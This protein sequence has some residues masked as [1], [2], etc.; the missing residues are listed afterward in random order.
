MVSNLDLAIVEDVTYSDLPAQVPA[1][2]IRHALATRKSRH[3]QHVMAIANKLAYFNK[4]TEW[5][6]ECERRL[7]VDPGAVT[8]TND[9]MTMAFP[10]SCVSHAIVGPN[11]TE[12]T[13]LRLETWAQESG[14]EVLDMRYSRRQHQP[15]F[16]ASSTTLTWD[17]DDFSES[18]YQCSTCE[19]PLD[20]KMNVCDWCDISEADIASA[21]DNQFMACLNHGII[22]SVPLCFAGVTIRGRK[23]GDAKA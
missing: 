19:E 4:R 7:I 22:D 13:K 18:I 11:A 10:S 23:N 14:V 1:S 5:S 9:I 12:E 16:N 2:R 8:K 17:G 15:Y 20:E 21:T 3:T 6:Y